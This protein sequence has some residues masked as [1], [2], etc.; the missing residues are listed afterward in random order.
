V[1][2]LLRLQPARP[3]RA[4]H[5]FIYYRFTDSYVAV[6]RH[7]L[8]RRDLLPRVR[9][10]AGRRLACTHHAKV[11]PTEQARRVLAIDKPVELRALERVVPYEIARDVVLSVPLSITLTECACR[12]VAHGRGEHDPDLCGPLAQCL[13]LGDPIASYAAEHRPDK[14]RRLTVDEALDV[15]EQAA[16]RGAVHTLWFKDAAAGRMYALCNC[17]SCCCVGLQAHREGFRPLVGSGYAAVVTDDLC[18][19][20]GR[21]VDVCPFGALSLAGDDLV[22]DTARCFGCGTCARTCEQDALHLQSG[23]TDIEPLPL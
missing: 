13:Y 15:V 14:S 1:R 21:C 5:G 11:V 12:A 16:G 17:C 2:K 22:V 9:D 3:D 4:V 6:V 7:F 10:W 23:R 20:C 8:E 19:G 18:T